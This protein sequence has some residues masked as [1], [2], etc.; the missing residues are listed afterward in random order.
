MAQ[1]DVF[2]HPDARMRERTPYLLDLQN[3]SL[4]RIA[5]RI[6]I[7]LRSAEYVPLPM[8]DLNPVCMVNG[9]SVVVD[10]AALSAVPVRLLGEP[11][12]N[13]RAQAPEVLNALDFLFGGQ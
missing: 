13:L 4:E 3:S 6:V 8:R 11:L 5:T 2:P 12:L 7:P 10:T 9:Q 1:Y